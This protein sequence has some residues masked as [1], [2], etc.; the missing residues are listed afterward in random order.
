MERARLIGEWGD[1]DEPGHRAATLDRGYS[2]T[3]RCRRLVDI[4]ALGVD[5]AFPVAKAVDDLEGRVV[6][7]I[8]TASRNGTPAS[9]E[10]RIRAAPARSKRLRRTPARKVSGTSENEIRKSTHAIE[11]VRL[12]TWS[13][14]TETVSSAT[15]MPHER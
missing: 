5:P 12:E 4:P 15:E 3:R 10:S 13:S 7:C 14:A 2:T 11:F 6:Q 1:V 8:A 9:S